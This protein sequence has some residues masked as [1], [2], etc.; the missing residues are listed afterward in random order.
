MSETWRATC[1]DCS[2]A[3]N[4]A[5]TTLLRAARAYSKEW[6]EYRDSHT[7]NSHAGGQSPAAGDRHAAGADLRAGLLGLLIRLSARPIGAQGARFVP[8]PDDGQQRWLG[9]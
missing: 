4:P 6:L 3:R 1:S 9:T 7:R 8:Q 2:T 5:R